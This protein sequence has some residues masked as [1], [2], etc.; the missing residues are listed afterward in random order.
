MDCLPN[1]SKLSVVAVHGLNG[2]CRR[3]WTHVDPKTKKETLWLKDMLPHKMPYVRPM[4]FGY[5][6]SILAN[7]SES[8]VRDNARSLLMELRNRR[9]RDGSKARPI[10]FIG[11]S[12][13]GIIIKQVT[14]SRPT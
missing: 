1:V 14:A 9:E 13:G 6:A 11:H 7:T 2:D 3:T 12:L 10:V 4:T 5:H 8:G